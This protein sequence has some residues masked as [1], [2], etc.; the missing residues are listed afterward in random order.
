MDNM[1]DLVDK[2]NKYAYHYYVLDEPLISDKEY[3]E[4]YDRLVLLEKETGIVL[5]DS[6]TRRVGGEIIDAFTSFTHRSRLYS[7]DKAKT[8]Q[9]LYNWESRLQRAAGKPD[10]YTVE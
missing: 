9:E 7:L 4:L 1:R 10:G 8:E 2:L 5:S 6:P 3:D